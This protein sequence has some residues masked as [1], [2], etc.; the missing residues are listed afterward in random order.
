MVFQTLP[1][2]WQQ[3]KLAHFRWYAAQHP[4]VTKSKPK[5]LITLTALLTRFRSL[6]RDE[7]Y[8]TSLVTS[9]TQYSSSIL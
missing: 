8:A 9:S 2:G 5:E 7:V 6:Y 1:P 4:E 3:Y